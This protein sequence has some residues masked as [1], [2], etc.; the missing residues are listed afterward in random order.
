MRKFSIDIRGRV[1]N[2]SLP[3]N[4]PLIP[5]FEAVVNSIHAIAE[6]KNTDPSFSNGK[7]EIIIERDT[8]QLTFDSGLPPVE[9]FIIVDNGIGFNDDNIESF[10]QSDSTYKERI[11]GKGVGRFSWL[12]AFDKAIIESVYKEND[13]ILKRTFEFSLNNNTIDDKLVDYNEPFN[14]NCTT[15]KLDSYKSSYQENVPK[16]AITIAMRLI[17]HCLV[18]FISESCPQIIIKDSIDGG[19]YNLNNIFNEKIKTDNNA[20][21]FDIHGIKFNILNV[22]IQDKSANGNKLYLCA[23]NRV[24]IEKDLDKYIVDL[25]KTIYENHGF[26]YIGVLTS[27]YFDK[28]VDM[29]RL[30]FNIPENGNNCL[31]LS[32]E[33]IINISKEKVEQYLNE[34]LVPIADKK[35][36]KIKSYVTHIAPEFRHLL[37][38]MPNEIRSIKPNLTEDKLDD[39]LYQIKRKFDKQIKTENDEILCKLQTGAIGFNEYENLFDN[40]IS[41][42]SDANGA[43]LAEYVAH[44]KVIIDLL[45]VGI[46]KKD[47]GKFHK[48]SFIHKIFYPM[49]A[50]SESVDYNNHNLWLIDERLAYSSYICSDLPFDFN[51]NKERPD[52]LMLD[53]PVAVSETE[54]DGTVFD[55]ITIFELKRPMRDDYTRQDNPINQMYDYVDKIQSGKVKDINGRKITVGENTKYYLYAVCDVTESLQKI[56]RQNSFKKTTDGMGYYYYN[57]EYPAY[58]EV[59]PFDK[60][61]NA[62]KQR[63]KILF[64]KLGI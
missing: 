48:E 64:D 50:N 31:D 28:N 46:K 52:L 30:S 58:I 60:I 49:K 42:I 23:N 44:R 10:S 53:S 13:E 61:I 3:K 54:N 56:L 4:Q 41:K 63:N 38:Y 27:D 2:F 16:Q 12:L 6:R 51:E 33:E 26:Y 43:V 19:K 47:D 34:Y 18:Y 59:L 45:E 29:N 32:I 22:K 55:S 9:S 40:Q 8:S 21:T 1:K 24:V 20:S 37:K 25:D 39:E 15:I 11:G 57:D 5:L 14:D 62:A 17:E 35:I 36:D 7:I